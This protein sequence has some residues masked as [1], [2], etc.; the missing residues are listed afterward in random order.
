MVE[1]KDF[2]SSVKTMIGITGEYQD[3]TILGYIEEVL[4]Y[5]KEAGVKDSY[6]TLNKIKGVV[7]RGVS[8]L[9]NYGSGGTTFSPY[10]FQRVT[11]LSY[12][13]EEPSNGEIST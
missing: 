2:L 6:F 10:F 5:M 8:D 7:V 4:D 3:D 1:A 9:W 12:K 13:K 11:Q